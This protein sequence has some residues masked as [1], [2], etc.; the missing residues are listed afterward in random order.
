[1]G[2]PLD[3]T[4]SASEPS[5]DV[6]LDGEPADFFQVGTEDTTSCRIYLRY[7]LFRALDDFALRDTSREQAGML[8]GRRS[9]QGLW[10]KVEEAL[11]VALEEGATRFSER[12]WQRARRVVRHRH[13]GLE[14]VGWF[15]TH[16]GTGADLSS[17]E[18]SLHGELFTEP[19]QVLYAVDPVL[20][21]R[22]FH[23]W[24]DADL[25]RASGFRI[26]GKEEEPMKV[27]DREP[28]RPDEHLRERYVERSLEKLQ[29]LVRHPPV[30]MVDYVLIALLVL[31]LL[32]LL[33]RPAPSVQ[34]DD[35]KLLASQAQLTSDVEDLASRMKKLEEHLAAIRMLDEELGLAGETAAPETPQSPEPTAPATVP[36]PS[37]QAG[38]A[39]PSPNAS[40][41]GVRIRLHK[42]QQGDTLS[43]IAEKYYGTADPKLAAALGNYNRLKAPNFDIWPGDSLK[44]P[45]RSALKT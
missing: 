36:S 24:R 42:V 9:E 5:Q 25:V 10:L 30:R 3:T 18:I 29:R 37:P 22:A 4:P 1:M 23:L 15:H 13:P 44:I 17:D 20:R 2:E 11:D 31:N 33:F 27:A 35:K 26:Y 12:S 7:P 8:L 39:S 45:P 28:S 41:P 38:P 14:V 32:V 16:P 19:W 43:R 34:L 6:P 21:E 40:T